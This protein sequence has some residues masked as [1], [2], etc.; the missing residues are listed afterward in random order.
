MEM[1][2]GLAARKREPPKL[3]FWQSTGGLHRL[4]AVSPWERGAA[5][6]DGVGRAERALQ[7]IGEILLQIRCICADELLTIQFMVAGRGST[8]HTVSTRERPPAEIRAPC[9]DWCAA[10]HRRRRP[11][12]AAAEISGI[13]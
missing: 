8:N 4:G 3:R 13:R 7:P 1:N 2:N 9:R 5:G 10:P 12:S 6:S 11:R